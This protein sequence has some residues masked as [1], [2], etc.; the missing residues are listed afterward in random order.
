MRE[1]EKLVELGEKDLCCSN[2]QDGCR[3]SWMSFGEKLDC[4]GSGGAMGTGEPNLVDI[5]N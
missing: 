4:S 5:T 3:I 2:R 1:K